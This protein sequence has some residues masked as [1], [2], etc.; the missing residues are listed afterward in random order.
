MCR[1]LS[2]ATESPTMP[3][4]WL[5]HDARLEHVCALASQAHHAASGSQEELS[6]KCKSRVCRTRKSCC[7]DWY[8]LAM[9][10][11]QAK[12]NNIWVRT[13][14]Q[15]CLLLGLVKGVGSTAL[16]STHF[17]A[18]SQRSMQG[19]YH[20]NHLGRPEGSLEHEQ[21]SETQRQAGKAWEAW[22][23]WEK[24]QSSASRFQAA[25]QCQMTKGVS[26]KSGAKPNT[27]QGFV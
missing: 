14:L 9:S 27:D 21:D 13:W 25:D 4:Q 17:Q 19:P 12:K 18:L 20:Q 5:S 15:L 11:K 23:E 22:M 10:S 26:K 16:L 2:E 8:K 24:F 3:S 6:E 7:R 1:R